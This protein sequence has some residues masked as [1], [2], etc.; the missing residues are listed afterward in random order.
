MK[1]QRNCGTKYLR[2]LLYYHNS[3]HSNRRDI[4]CVNSADG[5]EKVSAKI[6]YGSTEEAPSRQ[7]WMRSILLAGI[8]MGNTHARPT[9][10]ATS[11]LCLGTA[12]GRRRLDRRKQMEANLNGK[13]TLCCFLEGILFISV[14][15]SKI[16]QIYFFYLIYVKWFCPQ[17][18]EWE[19]ETM[20]K[21]VKQTFFQA[22][23]E[24]NFTYRY[25]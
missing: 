25:R 24:I 23:N 22:E 1:R 14:D 13:E 2:N 5:L 10:A 11:P 21:K 12:L 7:T 19:S 16:I 8:Y 18:E 9:S 15:F 3:L 20:R 17:T 4:K 6:I